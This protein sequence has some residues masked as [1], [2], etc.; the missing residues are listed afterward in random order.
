MIEENLR[1]SQALIESAILQVNDSQKE[2]ENSKS[3][4]KIAKNFKKLVFAP[5]HHSD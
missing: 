1:A 2:D 4:N 5:N 3:Q